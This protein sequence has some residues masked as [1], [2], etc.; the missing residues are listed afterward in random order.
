MTERPVG[1]ST[2]T[3]LPVSCQ[4]FLC[5]SGSTSQITA[6]ILQAGHQWWQH[7]VDTSHMTWLQQLPHTQTPVL[8]RPEAWGPL[9]LCGFCTVHAAAT[10]WCY[11]RPGFYFPRSGL[12]MTPPL[13]RLHE[14]SAQWVSKSWKSNCIR[15]AVFSITVKELGKQAAHQN[16]L[17]KVLMV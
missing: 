3:K 7:W 8:Q 9:T 13:E 5:Y 16:R 10:W 2:G 12:Q 15:L 4:I 17:S 14:T 1:K 11:S 6:D